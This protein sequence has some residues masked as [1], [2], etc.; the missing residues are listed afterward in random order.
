M[1]MTFNEIQD[2]LET[3]SRRLSELGRHL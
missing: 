1:T 2:S 3:L